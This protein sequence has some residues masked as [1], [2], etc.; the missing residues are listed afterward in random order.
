[1]SSIDCRKIDVNRQW[2]HDE[3][4]AGDVFNEMLC[5][6]VFILERKDNRVK[7]MT[8][9]G[10]CELPKDGKVADVTVDQFCERYC[11]NSKSMRHKLWVTLSDRGGKT[12]E[13]L[14]AFPD[15]PPD[16]AIYPKAPEPKEHIC[17]HCKRVM[18]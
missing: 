9:Q 4:K 3:M 18:P 10:P 16:E 15:L 1:M 2:I 12:K 13:A 5:H 8:A 7:I 17:P 11:Y 14:K 6:W